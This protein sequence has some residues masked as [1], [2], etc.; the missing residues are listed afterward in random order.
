MVDEKKVKKAIQLLLEGLGEDTEREGLKNTPERVARMYSEILAG[1]DEDAGEHLSRVF[2]DETES[3][4][5]VMEKDISF[6]STCEHHLMPFFGKVHVAYIPNGQVVGLSKLARTVEV[7]ARRLQM[8]ERMTE[9]IADALMEH[10]ECD[11]V[12]V[13]VE[14][15]HQAI[16]FQNFILDLLYRMLICIIQRQWLQ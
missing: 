13:M 2:P 11:G 16:R 1:R 6:F 8:Q 12:M 7:F 4:A 14:A 5:M 3:G 9:Q 10:L 15:E